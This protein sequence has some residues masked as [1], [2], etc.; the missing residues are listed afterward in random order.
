[1]TEQPVEEK[2]KWKRLENLVATLQ[3]EFSPEARVEKNIRVRGRRS[4]TDRQIDVAVRV[5]TGQFELFIAID[6]KDYGSK[7][8]VKDVEEFM[9]LV[10]DV[11]A[12]QG[13]LVTTVGYTEAAKKRAEVAGMR[14]FTLVDAESQDWPA[15]VTVPVVVDVR[16]M[17]VSYE[18]SSTELRVIN[19]DVHLERVYREDGS[20]IGVFGDIVRRLWNT[21]A[22][23]HEVGTCALPVP[24]T[25][26]ATYFQAEAGL[27]RVHLTAHVMV[28][29]QLYLGS[30]RL[31]RI[32][33]LLDEHGGGVITKSIKTERLDA[34]VVEKTWKKVTEADIPVKPL[35]RLSYSNIY[36]IDGDPEYDE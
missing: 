4:G 10:E 36:R 34:E 8:D 22:I 35:F 20:L 26:E 6:C 5:K 27:A 11:G 33:G 14:L 3:K 18:L 29:S 25:G 1:M 7:V 31:V 30:L 2:K 17:K 23:S 12:H 16:S 9:G 28:L 24:P 13:A 32:R 19:P 21:K 15:I